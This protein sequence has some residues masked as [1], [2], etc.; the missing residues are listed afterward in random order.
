MVNPVLLG[1]WCNLFKS[2]VQTHPQEMFIYVY[3]HQEVLDKMLDHLY[4]PQM[5]E[6]YVRM[7]NF[8][9]SVFT[10][11]DPASQSESDKNGTAQSF[12]ESAAQEIR[13]CTVFSIIERIGTGYS[14]DQQKS[15]LNCLFELPDDPQ[16]LSIMTRPSSLERIKSFLQIDDEGVKTNCFKLLHNLLCRTFDKPVENDWNSVSSAGVFSPDKEAQ[17]GD[18]NE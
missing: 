8:N 3:E 11:K 17:R 14:F 13:S 12:S 9:K 1:Y 2:F 6:I 5:S 10:R 15:A 4:S 18:E 7:L 16:I